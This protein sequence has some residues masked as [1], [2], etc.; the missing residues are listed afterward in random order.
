MTKLDKLKEVKTMIESVLTE[1]ETRLFIEN[2]DG[3]REK[4][5]HEEKPKV[6]IELKQ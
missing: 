2:P 6:L 5:I 4:I 3:V 1:L